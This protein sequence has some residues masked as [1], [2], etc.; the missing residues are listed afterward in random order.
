MR[1]YSEEDE[2]A[3]E[4][5][6]ILDAGDVGV[7]GVLVACDGQTIEALSSALSAEGDGLPSNTVRVLKQIRKGAQ[8]ETIS[9]PQC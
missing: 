3:E 7:E 9:I 2:T 1:I 8:V 4:V 6:V 5:P